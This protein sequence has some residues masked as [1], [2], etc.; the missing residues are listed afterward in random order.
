M[1]ITTQKILILSCGT[2]GGHNSVAKAIQENLIERGINVDF[3]EYLDIINPRIRNKVN[4]LYIKSTRRN[5]K[6]FK[7]VYKLG[8]I[9]EK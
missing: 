9:Y 3:I 6:I 1:S 5:G 7:V 2:G 8:E 4:N